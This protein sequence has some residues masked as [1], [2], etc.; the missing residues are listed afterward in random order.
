MRLL[1]I[2]LGFLVWSIAVL[3]AAQPLGDE[4][5]RFF[6]TRVGFSPSF[7]EVRQF[8]GLSR[9]QAVDRVLM[10]Q[11][12]AVVP[13]PAWID[14]PL[15][16]R[17]YLNSLSPEEKKAQ[18]ELDIRQG[19]ELRGWWLRQ[20]LTTSSPLSERMT[21]FWH[22]H[23]VSSQKKVRSSLL[24]YRQNMLL[25]QHALG[26][27][28]DLLHAVSKDP[29]ML[30]Y[31]DN[32]NSRKGAPN[33]NFAREVM[34]L[35]TLSEGH[36]GEQDI[37]EA[38]R[39]FTGWSIDLENGGFKWRP[40]F[41][42]GGIKTV[43]GKSGNFKGDDVLDILLAQPACAEFIVTKLWREFVSP[44][45]EPAEVARIARRFRD[46]GYD[47]KIALREL[48]LSPAFW[49]EKNRATLVKSPVELAVGALKQ[50]EFT[51]GDP[52]PFTFAVAQLGQNLLNPPNVK[53]W[54]GGEAW[55]N[56]TTLLARK[57]SLERL[58]RAVEPGGGKIARTTDMMLRTARAEMNALGKVKGR[59]ALGMEGKIQYANAVAEVGF[60]PDAWLAQFGTS[61]DKIPDATQRLA[62]QR[63][64]LAMPPVAPISSDLNGLAYLRALVMDPVYQL[65]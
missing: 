47:T 14:Q 10:P 61:A 55:I 5:A 56:S 18:V 34:E 8:A 49:S 60:N 35:F 21:L 4:D 44:A 41:H 24:M 3:A 48:F 12:V 40:M 7:S 32:A 25:R 15:V 30:I 26:N 58:F 46:S 62:M 50:F 23:F 29:A 59:A 39:A 9:Q 51:Y 27:F 19:I 31:L 6:L 17:K 20:M 16:T 22:N 1:R 54:P 13:A 64:I 57:A 33:E 42:D 38:A 52:L 53:G 2:G 43:L 63:A 28:G 36:Y 11:V 65:K 37:K 45:A